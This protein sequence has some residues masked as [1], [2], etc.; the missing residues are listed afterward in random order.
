ME[1]NAMQRD[2]IERVSFWMVH[3]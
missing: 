1:S 2:A 3:N